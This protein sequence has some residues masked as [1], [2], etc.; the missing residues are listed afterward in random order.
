MDRAFIQS[1]INEFTDI[2]PT[3]F[4]QPKTTDEETL[5]KLSNY[6]FGHNFQ[7]N[8]YYGTTP[9]NISEY[10]AMKTDDNIGLKFY[11]YPIFSIGR[12]DDPGFLD[13][14]KPEV[15]GEH[16]LMPKDWLPEAKTVISFFIPFEDR[17]RDSNIPDPLYASDEWLFGR[18]DGQQ[19]LYSVGAL[20][21]KLLTD[22]GY[23]AVCPQ[24]DDRYQM[25]V[26]PSD[27]GKTIP[28][29]STNW[30]ERHVGYVT[31]L[32]T[33]GL[34]T[35]FI[36]KV[37]ACGRLIS[38]VTDWDVPAD[39]KDYSHWLDYCIKCG[40]CI[41]RCPSKAITTMNGEKDNAI[42]QSYIHNACANRKPRYG[43]GKCMTGIPCQSKCPVKK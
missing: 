31:G 16:H 20:V 8:N 26:S 21:V 34:S 22:A 29:Y 35:D 24:A 38:V 7:K 19:H 6:F 4:L 40:A 9:N 15:V 11:K 10:D 33:F 18:V 12:A 23:K 2:S 41:R 27:S 42:C 3:N 30:S 17:I 37:G 13:I 36:S 43:C 14:K 25:R 1:A 39:E 5:K 32:G 28:P